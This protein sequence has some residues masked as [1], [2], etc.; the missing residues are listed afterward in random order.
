M[1]VSAKSGRRTE[2][3][4]TNIA[5]YSYHDPSRTCDWCEDIGVNM[6]PRNVATNQ[7]TDANTNEIKGYVCG[8]CIPGLRR[9]YTI[10]NP[11]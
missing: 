4:V 3:P 6:I 5:L 1:T 2:H 7:V 8:G 10:V 9:Y 11:I